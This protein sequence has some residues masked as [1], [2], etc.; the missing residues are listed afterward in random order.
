LLASAEL[1]KAV[2]FSREPGGQHLGALKRSRVAKRVFTSQSL[3]R[4][5]LNRPRFR[6]RRDLAKLSAEAYLG[7]QFLE[8]GLGGR[9]SCATVPVGWTASGENKLRLVAG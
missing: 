1:A 3:Y 8:L 6:R 5:T 2:E 4:C 7:V 9:G